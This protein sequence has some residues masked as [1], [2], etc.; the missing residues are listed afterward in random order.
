MKQWKWAEQAKPQNPKTPKPQVLG[1]K[2]NKNELW[3]KI[4]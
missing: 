1:L 3:I 2:I 4:I